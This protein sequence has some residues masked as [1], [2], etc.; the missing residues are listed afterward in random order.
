ML[1]FIQAR[2]VSVPGGWC[3]LLVSVWQ[4][5]QG[6]QNNNEDFSEHVCV[7]AHARMRVCVRAHVCIISRS[8]HK[9]H[10]FVMTNTCLLWQN[11][12]F[13]ARKVCLSW[14]NFFWQTF[15]SW[16]QFCC[17]KLTFVATNRCL[18]WQNTSFV[19][20][21]VCLSQQN[22]FVACHSK[23]TFV[24]TKDMFCRDRHVFVMTNMCL[25]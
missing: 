14:Q 24:A 13:V 17:D 25:S 4:R 6:L 16:Q 20:T 18:S 23:H 12:S 15:L 21:K 7:C 5:S 10:V 2:S 9:L 3:F 1:H 8:C 19:V 11:T 22:Y